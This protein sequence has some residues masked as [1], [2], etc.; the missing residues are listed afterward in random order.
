MPTIETI[1]FELHSLSEFAPKP[2]WIQ[3][4]HGKV[5]QLPQIF[6]T[7]GRPWREVNAWLC[8]LASNRSSDIKTV[9]S[10]AAALLSYAKW[11]ETNLVSWMEIHGRRDD[12]CI[13]RYRGALIM[14]RQRGDAAA[15]TVSSRIRVIRQFYAWVIDNRLITL[16]TPLWREKKIQIRFTDQ[17][18]FGRSK[19]VITTDLAIPYRGRNDPDLEDGLWPVS[20]G[21]RERILDCARDHAPYEIYLMLLLGFHTGM[22]I[23][24]IG[25]LKVRTILNAVRHPLQEL[26]STIH[27]GPGAR[28]TVATKYGITGRIEIPTSLVDELLRYSMSVERLTRAARALDENQDLLF[29]TTRG[30][31]YSRHDRNTS[32]AINTAMNALRKHGKRLGINALLD[33]KFHQSRATY[34]TE[35][36]TFALHIDPSGAIDMVRRNLLHKDEATTMKYIRFVKQSPVIADISNKYTKLFL[37]RYNEA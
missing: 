35:H 13:I 9:Q 15:S 25:D 8:T 14:A 33:F 17:F 29:I 11:L 22:R 37:G 3:S 34:A 23:Q 27:I 36:A 21:D 30:N 16:S 5:E 10:K 18:G 28:P 32:G 31:R 1:T 2:K 6:W 4:E 26:V 20:T 12:R 19:D 7:D 24:S